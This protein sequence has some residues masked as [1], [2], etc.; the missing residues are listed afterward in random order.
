MSTMNSLFSEAAGVNFYI[1]DKQ[2]RSK[3]GIEKH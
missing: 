1:G 2:I 3:N